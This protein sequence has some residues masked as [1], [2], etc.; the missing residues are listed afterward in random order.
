MSSL[1]GNVKSLVGGESSGEE[2]LLGEGGACS[3]PLKT[4]GIK[5]TNIKITNDKRLI[6]FGVLVGLAILSSMLVTNYEL[7]S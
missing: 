5:P 2:S 6:G 1:L 3:L 4:V 7:I